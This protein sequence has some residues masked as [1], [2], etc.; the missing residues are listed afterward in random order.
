MTIVIGPVALHA[1]AAEPWP[2]Y[3]RAAARLWWGLEDD[4][5][6]R[7]TAGATSMCTVQ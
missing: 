7:L 1:R 3:R 5:R 6:H 2:P 4:P